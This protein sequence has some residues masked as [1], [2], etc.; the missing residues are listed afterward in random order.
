MTSPQATLYYLTV[1]IQEIHEMFRGDSEGDI[2]EKIKQIELQ[3][4]DIMAAQ[5]RHENLMNLI[6][7]LWSKE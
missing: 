1:R 3:M 5:Q 6:I 4:Q 2:F 7:K